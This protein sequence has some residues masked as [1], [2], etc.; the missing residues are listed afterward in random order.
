M[1]TSTF[2]NKRANSPSTISNLHYFS[3][4]V[5]FKNA[6]KIYFPT[7]GYTKGDL[8]NYYKMV[9]P[10]LLPHL[11]SRPQS[12]KRQPDGIVNNG[13][14]QKNVAGLAP[15]WIHTKKI[16][17][18]RQNELIEWLV[19]HNIDSLLFIVNIGC[20]EMNPWLSHCPTL[21]QPDYVIFD[22]D[23][24]QNDIVSLVSAALKINELLKS[25]GIKSFIKTSGAKGLHIFVPLKSGYNFLQTRCFANKI[26]LQTQK[27]LPNITTT[28]RNQQ[29][30]IGKIYLDYL[31]NAKGK[32]M[33]SVY[34][35]RPINGAPISTP[36]YWEE[37]NHS[38]NLKAFNLKTIEKRLQEKGDI[39][40]TFFDE[41]N[42][43]TI[44]A[45]LLYNTSE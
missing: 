42:K 8:I 44:P 40:A 30:R 37:V 10:Y 21:D 19:C 13:F 45:D 2:N 7:D 20:I 39:W 22:L 38:L 26:C 31:Q 34:S 33:V 14:F 35:I 15:K 24:N 9:S 36:L 18:T 16:K 11:I 29:D 28:K 17:T 6:D 5:N 1:D 4:K 25:Y 41:N 27:Q 3:S 43:Q 23:P 32:T 12:L